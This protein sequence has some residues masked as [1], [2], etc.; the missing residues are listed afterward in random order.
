MTKAELAYHKLASNTVKLM[1]TTKQTKTSLAK[2]L[3]EAVLASEDILATEVPVELVRG[4]TSE[5]YP[6]NIEGKPD[7]FSPLV[8]RDKPKVSNLDTRMFLL[9]ASNIA[10]HVITL[11]PS[12]NR[13]GTRIGKHYSIFE[14]VY[15]FTGRLVTGNLPA[16]IKKDLKT[17]KFS[18]YNLARAIPNLIS[19]RVTQLILGGTIT[20]E[21]AYENKIKELRAVN[22]N[23]ALRRFSEIFE[24]QE[25]EEIMS[26]WDFDTYSAGKRAKERY[27]VTSYSEYRKIYDD[28]RTKFIHNCIKATRK[29]LLKDFG[30]TIES[31]EEPEYDKLHTYSNL[32]TY[33]G[34]IVGCIGEEKAYKF[35]RGLSRLAICNIIEPLSSYNLSDSTIRNVLNNLSYQDWVKNFECSTLDNSEEFDWTGCPVHLT[36]SLKKTLRLSTKQLKFMLSLMER[37][38]KGSGRYSNDYTAHAFCSLLKGATEVRL[39]F[40]EDWGVYTPEDLIANVQHDLLVAG[41]KETAIDDGYLSVDLRKCIAYLVTLKPLLKSLDAQ[42][43]VERWDEILYQEFRIVSNY[44]YGV[45]D[46]E[47]LLQ[48]ST[49]VYSLM[50]LV[51]TPKLLEYLYYQ[52][53]ARQGIVYN[54]SRLTNIVDIYRDY[55][56]QSGAIIKHTMDIYRAS[57][58]TKI[59]KTANRALSLDKYPKYL[60]YAH[61]VTARNYTTLMGTTNA[62]LSFPE[63]VIE[64]ITKLTEK[65]PTSAQ[66]K[67]YTFGNSYV[68]VVPQTPSEL[69]VEGQQLSHCVGSYV[70]RVINGTSRILFLRREEDPNKPYVTVE[71]S[72]NN[73]INQA[74]GFSDSVV[75]NE[76]A[77]V[78]IDWAKR[79]GFT[80][81]FKQ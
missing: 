67:G 15:D 21:F 57:G 32:Y 74:Y 39:P 40:N 42:Y 35:S 71:V 66:Q 63:E 78:L 17:L 8:F 72:L 80:I 69:V 24:Y 64:D 38:T 44:Y 47:Y 6:I 26:K 75:S 46:V 81:S 60:K 12:D 10:F 29:A 18:E 28:K 13:Y 31:D 9:R 25:G 58:N 62:S 52:L 43:G 53:E 11:V 16:F 37:E 45:T 5:N 79:A 7:Y 54:Y 55:L 19:D 14:T 22:K 1:E 3:I 30:I 2:E 59:S 51:D 61:D 4:V 49:L 50:L 34:Q 33:A 77:Q 41:T 36:K 73:C 56:T 68:I 48:Y 76:V 65:F 27:N 70:N 20:P 23:S